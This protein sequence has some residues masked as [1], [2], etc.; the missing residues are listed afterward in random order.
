[1]EHRIFRFVSTSLHF[2]IIL[3]FLSIIFFKF[4]F[5]VIF[6]LNLSI[7]VFPSFS[8]FFPQQCFNDLLLESFNE[9]FFFF[10]STI[11]IIYY[12]IFFLVQNVLSRPVHV[13]LLS[14]FNHNSCFDDP[15]LMGAILSPAQLADVK[16][17]KYLKNLSWESA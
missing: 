1:M 5:V 10:L 15:G 12:S 4:A 3:V 2:Q 17:Q 16:G 11:L 13:P 14:Y 7:V 6:F 9:L 8:S